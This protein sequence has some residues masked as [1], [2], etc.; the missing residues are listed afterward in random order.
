M[1][2]TLDPAAYTL[3]RALDAALAALWS[4]DHFAVDGS[5]LA[6]LN[7]CVAAARPEQIVEIGT[8]T[9]L[10]TAALASMMAHHGLAGTVRSYDLRDVLWFDPDRAVGDLV[11]RIAGEEAGRVQL[12]SGVTALA[13]AEDAAPESVGLAFVD[14]GHQHPW[15]LLDTLLLLPLMRLRAPLV[16]HDLQ[17]YRNAQNPVGVGPKMLFD[18][19][20]PAHRAVA[21]DLGLGMAETQTPSRAVADNVF[22]MWRRENLAR[23]GRAL[24]RGL[25]LPWSLTAPLEDASA[26]EIVERL[27][28]NY[29]GE[30]VRNFEIGHDRFR[31]AQDRAAPPAKGWRDRL[32]L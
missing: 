19:L 15:P 5:D 16:H 3:P 29:P 4:E 11:P 12:R 18:Q 26:A 25:L 8:A 31:A 1:L 7:M 2:E 17:L 23:Q 22:L 20:S 9:G 30:V 14:A 27:R 21:S 13:V 24:S 6:F 32:G 28:E 10:S